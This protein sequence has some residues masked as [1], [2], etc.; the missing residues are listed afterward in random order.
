MNKDQI[1]LEKIKPDTKLFVFTGAGVSAASGVPTFRDAGGLW[2]KYRPEELATESAFRKDPKLV[3][4]WYEWRRSLVRK[5]QPNEAHLQISKL[6][7]FFSWFCLVTQNV[8]DLHERAGSTKVYHLHGNISENKCIDCSK[9]SLENHEAFEEPPRC[10]LCGGWLRPCV[11]WFGE[12]LPEDELTTAFYKAGQCDVFLSIGTGA[13]V[14]P[15][16]S[17]ISVAK[18]AGAFMVEFNPNSTEASSIMDLSFNEP[19]EEAL[20]RIF[21]QLN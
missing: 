10:E 5:A 13:A 2:G 7:K 12:P 18:Q 20:P 6:E 3:W 14:Q 4:S 19:V 17:V 21:K 11:V 16:A 15:A 9:L 8:D 1:L